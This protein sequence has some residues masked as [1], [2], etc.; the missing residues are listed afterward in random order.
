MFRRRSS[1]HFARVSDKSDLESIRDFWVQ[2]CAQ[3]GLPEPKKA[4]KEF[5][6]RLEKNNAKAKLNFASCKLN[7]GHVTALVEALAV[8]PT[9]SKLE[10]QGNDI[11]DEGAEI[12][13]K[14]LKGQCKVVR[15]VAQD[16]RLK[17]SFLGEVY[18]SGSN[19]EINETTL[20]DIQKVRAPGYV[21]LLYSPYTN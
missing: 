17:A 15:Q 19:F 1:V 9:V 11:S 2:K 14:L 10:L 5:K 12:I 6:K 7:D 21:D 3:D 20:N 4:L 8:S 18:L 13:F 16:E